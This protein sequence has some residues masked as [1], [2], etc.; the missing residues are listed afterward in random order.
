[1]RLLKAALAVAAI[2]VLAL[3]TVP[4]T[5]AADSVEGRDYTRLQMPQPAEANGKVEVIEFFWRRCR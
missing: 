1:M 4:M 2:G 3:Q 5:L